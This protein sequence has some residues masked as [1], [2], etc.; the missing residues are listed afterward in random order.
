MPR[1]V[2]IAA[3]LYFAVQ[4]ADA[5]RLGYAGWLF[6]QARTSEAAELNPGNATYRSDPAEAAALSPR[7]ATLRVRAGLA[8]EEAGRPVEAESALLAAAGLSRKYEPR[9]TLAGFYFRQNKTEPFWFWARAALPVAY[10]DP[11]ALFDLAWTL[12]DDG[13]RIRERLQPEASAFTWRAWVLYAARHGH[14]DELE[15]ALD[16]VAGIDPQPLAAALLADGRIGA[17][18]RFTGHDAL[19]WQPVPQEGVEFAR[20]PNG[21]EL[22]FKGRQPEQCDVATRLLA[23]PAT[24]TT[25]PIAGSVRGLAWRNEPFG[26]GGVRVTLR[27]ERPAGETRAAGKVRISE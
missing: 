14:L 11:E 12:E 10:R 23:P 5:V 22:A 27:Y 9:W 25:W 13:P 2:Q 18:T 20:T 7:D 24:R 15:A 4:A 17:L 21:F 6:G 3:A 1:F 16:R 19:D 26:A 8:L